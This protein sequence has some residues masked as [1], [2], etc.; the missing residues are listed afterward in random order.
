MRYNINNQ[1][2]IWC[3]SKEN[4]DTLA[5]YDIAAQIYLDNTIAHDKKRPEHALDKKKLLT[6]NLRK[7]FDTLPSGAKVL[8]IGSADGENAKILETFK[9]DVVASDVAPAFIAAC[10]KQG[11][12]TARINVL[13]D[14]LPTKLNGVLCW[15]V[16]VHFTP[17]DTELALK[18]IYDSLVENG[19]LVFNVI[20]NATHD[21][22]NQWMDFEGEYKMGAK[23][24]YAYY[25]K[26]EIISIINKTRFKIV[27]EWHEHGGHNDWFCFVLEK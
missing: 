1:K 27:S 15:R 13:K 26:N 11:L 12:K 22:S 14:D 4:D 25:S 24:Y 16:F 17:E 19:R 6:E 5:V 20:D 7:A 18:R 9:F 10:K 23:R 3:M 2:G 21:C 8:E